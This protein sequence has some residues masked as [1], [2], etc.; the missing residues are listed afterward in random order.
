MVGVSGWKLRISADFHLIDFFMFPLGRRV[1]CEILWFLVWGEESCRYVLPSV[2]DSF[3][4]STTLV[5][6]FF[7][8]W[9]SGEVSCSCGWLPLEFFRD[10]DFLFRFCISL[11]LCSCHRSPFSKLSSR[12]LVFIFVSLIILAC[13]VAFVNA[14]AVASEALMVSFSSIFSFKLFEA[15]CCFILVLW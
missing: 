7:G 12:R 1:F 5:F 3:V 4:R 10:F 11:V 2:G 8:A 9:W 13:S 6:C 15:V 14:R